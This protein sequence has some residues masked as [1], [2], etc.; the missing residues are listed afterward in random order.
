[1]SAAPHWVVATSNRG[2]VDEIRAILE[3]LGVEIASLREACA[4]DFPDE[5]AV[6]EDNAI[7]KARAAAEQL[8]EVAIADDSGL[9]VRG[10]DWGPGP[11]SARF[12]GGDLD[13]EGRVRALLAALADMA[14][15][16]RDARFVCVAALATPDGRVLTARGECAGRILADPVGG[17]GFG[18]DP[19][20]G[21]SDRPE[22]MA[23]LAS[24]EKNLLSHR[25]RA[26]RDLWE[27]WK[28]GKR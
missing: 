11:L 17:G 1:M 5:G 13:D 27:Q 22:A 23:E 3:P 26:L 6:Y 4:V 8:G 20:F 28:D 16:S 14:G 12:G 21:L 7:A 19:I 18:Y 10:L 15:D 24:E 2:K 25:G 9:E